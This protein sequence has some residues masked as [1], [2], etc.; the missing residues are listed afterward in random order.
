MSVGLRERALEALRLADVDPARSQNLAAELVR[1]ASRAGELGTLCVAE[2]ALGLSSLHLKDLARALRQLRTAVRVGER[3]GEPVLAA[4]A[5]MTLAFAMAKRGRTSQARR[6]IEAALIDLT[7]VQHARGLAQRGAILHQIGKL[8]EALVSYRAAL[9]GLRRARDHVW[10]QRVLTNRGVLHGH[11][12]ELAAAV[13][14][15]T[16]ADRLARK[17]GLEL[18]AAHIQ[19]DLGWVHSLGGDVPAALRHLDLAERRLRE[20]A[21]HTATVLMDRSELLLSAY[22]VT[23]A[24]QAAEQ[25]V[26]E[27]EQEHR[28]VLL[29]EARLLLA[30]ACGLLGDA[31]EAQRQAG[32]AVRE[33]GRQQRPRWQNLARYYRLAAVAAGDDPPPG[34]AGRLRRAAEA[35]DAAGWPAAS[36]EARLLCAQQ[37]LARRR[38]RQACQQLE[39][40]SRQRRRGPARLRARGWY[41]EALLRFTTGQRSAV[42]AARA[43]LAILD[44]HQATLGATDLR[45]RASGHRLQLSHLG[46]RIALAERNH[47]SVLTWAEQSRASQLLLRPISPA[48]DPV[49]AQN[50]A[51]LRA[52]VKEIQAVRGRGDNPARLLQRQIALERAVRDHCRRQPGNPAWHATGAVPVDRLAA[53][54]ADQ[55]LVEFF[56]LDATLHAV[57]VV[58]GQLR[59]HQL[60]PIATVAD[61]VDRLP[62]A[63]NR[64][65]RQPAD[66]A[67]AAASLVLL[68]HA[69]SALDRILLG[70]LASEIG[71]RALVLVP[72]GPLQST[73]WSILPSCTGRPVT[74]APSASLWYQARQPNPGTLSHPAIAAGP[75]LA[76]AQAEAEAVAAIYRTT[77]LVGAAATVDAV[78]AALARASLAHI[79][80]HGRFNAENPLFSAL[81]LADGQL[82]V[83]DLE[84]LDHV[85]ELVVLAACDSGRAVV[86]AGDELLGMSASFLAQ[87]TRVLVAS[88]LLVPDAEA[89][90]LM[91]AFHRLLS[92]GHLP[93]EALAQA[94]HQM[95]GQEPAVTAAA[96]GF[97]C[98]GSQLCAPT[99][100]A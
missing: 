7:G 96:A 60:G 29:P 16:E 40:A 28:E 67:R 90:P 48:E 62:F 61:L 34:L 44:A 94:Q 85:P 12:M 68:R 10:V 95:A 53:A 57:T 11:R 2:R 26:R 99:D 58:N 80:A 86:C 70:P 43:G 51:T 41:A 79:A 46:L 33:F 77:A 88:V 13:T 76:E 89:K 56:E 98:I 35:L 84:Q 23:E 92:A 100:H 18:S 17:L 45:A 72:T 78:S 66:S 59:L 5:R 31:A 8:D 15:L 91:I 38:I 42:A 1:L 55:A 71:D 83:Y 65:S 3:S 54:L 63:L 82:T 97:V 20:L 87:G 4:E 9:P 52:T 21:T 32:K 24:K 75:E 50:I 39:V 49:L 81:Q 19:Q 36:L 27:F 93:P 73:P 14:D 25:S 22:L 30:Q 74:V 37:A 69:A 47:A 6:E 64:M